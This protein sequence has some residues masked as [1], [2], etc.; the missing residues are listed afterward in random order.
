[1]TPFLQLATLLAIIIFAAKFF[2]WLSTRLGQPSVLG[3][4]LVGVLLGPSL[5]NITHLGFIN[6][7]HLSETIAQ[8]GE[9]GVLML[10][11]LAGMELNIRDLLRS[12][13]VAVLS[14]SLGVLLPVVMG[15]GLGKLFA[16]DNNTALF[17]G[18][19]LGATSVSI[20]AQTLMELKML[21]SRVGLGLL[22]A[23]VF[24]DIL[25]ILLL[26][27]FVAVVTNPSGGNF[28]QLLGIFVRMLLYLALSVGVG[29]WVLP[30]LAR[31]SLSLPLSQAA[32]SL[33]IIVM[34]LYALGAELI[35]GMAAITGTFI[36]GLM[37]SR[38]P[39]KSRFEEGMA[40]LAYGFFV[41]IFFVSIGL[42]INIRAL[43]LDALWLL[44]GVSVIAILGKWLGAGLGARLGGLTNRESI[45][46][47]AG[48]I[49][50]GEVGLIVASV[51]EAQGLVSPAE[52]SAVVG[53]VLVT[54]L[55][56]PLILR[57]LFNQPAPTQSIPSEPELST[58]DE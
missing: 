17:L 12:S 34:L 8:L 6:D 42:S 43:E 4:L 16:M 2:G 10:M 41:P 14:G 38:S 22:G 51:G 48:M 20:S 23:A 39:E 50:R 26:S 30:R 33:S 40:S 55:L 7:T 15:W 18:L 27:G 9:L 21:R 52:F 57:A 37:F 47:G 58:V 46:L 49:S 29:L 25:V 44:L 13:R 3:E 28:L 24:D 53:M 19:T 54:T 36:A 35:G 1:M 11:F 45:Q 5:L 32:L 31:K 56:T